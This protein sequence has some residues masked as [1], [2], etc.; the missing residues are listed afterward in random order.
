MQ[1]KA[2]KEHQEARTETNQVSIRREQVT[3]YPPRR[4]CGSGQGRDRLEAIAAPDAELK[5]LTVL[6]DSF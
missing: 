2:N 1:E 4:A 5:A 3:G 6:Y